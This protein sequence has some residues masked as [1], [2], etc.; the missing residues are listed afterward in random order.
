MIINNGTDMVTIKVTVDWCGKNYAAYIC[1]SRVGGVVLATSK[2]YSGLQKEAEE[3]VR[4]QIE[5]CLN[6]GDDLPEDI[7]K[8]N[9]QLE[10][11]KR[12]SAVLHEV[13]QYTTLSALSRVTGI[14]QAQ[15]SHYANAISQPRP[16]QRARIIEGLHK[17]GEFCMAVV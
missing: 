13:Q 3:S 16:L 12:I 17:I 4:F 11:E 2:T 6:D 5:G 7:Q 9:Y 1:D 10:F 15:L 14:R 8:G